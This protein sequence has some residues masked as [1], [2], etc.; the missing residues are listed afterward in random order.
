MYCFCC[1]VGSTGIKLYLIAQV[2][3]VFMWS[4]HTH[5]LYWLDHPFGLLTHGILVKFHTHTVLMALCLGLPGWTG[6]RKVK[7]IWIFL[8]QQRVSGS[9]IHWA[10]RK[11]APRSRQITMPATHHSVFYRPDALPVAQPTESKHWRQIT[12]IHT[13]IHTNLYSARIVRTNLRRYR[14]AGCLSSVDASVITVNLTD[15]FAVNTYSLCWTL[16]SCVV[17]LVF[18]VFYTRW[19]KDNDVFQ[20]LL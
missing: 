2:T 18:M 13:Y 7:P 17:S 5:H 9:G 11:S 8:K 16:H 6:T 19:C 14:G 12:W 3:E 20:A 1:S 10:I 15:T 4:I